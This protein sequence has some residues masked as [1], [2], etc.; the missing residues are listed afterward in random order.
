[1]SCSLVS[2]DGDDYTSSWECAT[3]IDH[4]L[5]INTKGAKDENFFRADLQLTESR[6]K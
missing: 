3:W 6:E 2:G 1:M 5:S 4:E